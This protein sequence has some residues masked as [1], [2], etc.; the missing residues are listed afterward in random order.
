MNSLPAEPQDQN[1]DRSLSR[2]PPRAPKR[3]MNTKQKFL[4]FVTLLALPLAAATGYAVHASA[5][6]CACGA[7]CPCDACDGSGDC[8]DC[9][10]GCAHN[11]P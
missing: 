1:C 8:G 9:G 3:G 6:S 11:A 4:A 5:S 2:L 10:G 7:S